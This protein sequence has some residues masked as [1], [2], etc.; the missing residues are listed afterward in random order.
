MLKTSKTYLIL[1][2]SI[3]L[4]INGCNNNIPKNVVNENN[5]KVQAYFCPL[6]DCDN[7][8]KNAVD[9][10]DSSVH[11][12][13]WDL[14]LEDL[15]K[16][17]GEKSHSADVKL[18]IDDR[19]Y[20]GQIK[21]GGVRVAKSSRYMHNKFCILDNNKVLTGSMNPTNNGANLNN[22][23]LIIIDSK[24]IAENYEDEFQE[25]WNGIYS[26]GSNVKYNKINTNIGVIE[27]YFC[28][29]DCTLEN[30][31]GVYR[32]I[33]L[34]GNAEKSVK[35]ASF[36][37]THEELGDEL[38]KADINGIDVEVLVERRQRNSLG[39][40]YSRL[41]DFGIDI[42][43]DGNKNNM[44]HKF[45]IIDDKI[46]VFGSPNFSLS[47]FNRNDENML[48]IYNENLALGFVREFDRLFG[49][50]EVV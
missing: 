29:E 43:V 41:R 31:G 44:H 8:I 35:I 13:F 7:I 27:N 50:G 28:P 15:T 18:I 37:F 9:D 14:D 3:L 32:M 24:Y 20:D 5:V 42:K 4:V 2:L 17:F 38:L 1:I 40:Q 30:N 19:N 23:N 39:S 26:S 46:V 36:S 6:N 33:D 21:G 22:N 16:T 47:G 25:L 11:C 10:A 34:I 49:E 12:A 48:I 45:A